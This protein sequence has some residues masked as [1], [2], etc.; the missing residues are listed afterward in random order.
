VQAVETIRRPA[1]QSGQGPRFAARRICNV[2]FRVC[3]CGLMLMGK[4]WPT[5]R[6]TDIPHQRCVDSTFVET[7]DNVQRKFS[8]NCNHICIHVCVYVCM[9]SICVCKPTCMKV[10]WRG[11]DFMVHPLHIQA[12]IVTCMY[13]FRRDFGLDIGFTDPFN[14]IL[15]T[16]LNYIAIANSHTLRITRYVFSSP[17][18]LY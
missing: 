6:I 13:D 11:L 15:V 1:V 14:T 10:G 3:N 8:H 5:Q 16:T 9:M 4:F 12:C 18:C 7:T 17:Q 2:G